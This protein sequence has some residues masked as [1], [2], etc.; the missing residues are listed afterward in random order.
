MP[1]FK[2]LG[3]ALGDVGGFAGSILGGLTGGI[4]DELGIKGQQFNI[5]P[6]QARQVK[7]LDILSKERDKPVGEELTPGGQKTKELLE[8]LKEEA[9]DEQIAQQS[10]AISTALSRGREGGGLD[11]GSTERITR[12]IAQ[13]GLLA[14]QDI[15]SSF[16]DRL[17]QLQAEDFGGQEA[18][19]RQLITLAP[20]LEAQLVDPQVKV[21]LG[22]LAS[23]SAAQGARAGIFGSLI[24]GG[25]KIAAAGIG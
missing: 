19:R 25:S 13:R 16:A 4:A 6:F 11:V 7:A 15:G 10:G 20:Q 2:S 22:N 18:F 5:S 21:G 12:D 14:S 24:G 17:L 8:N 3:S 23:E 9:Q 1:L